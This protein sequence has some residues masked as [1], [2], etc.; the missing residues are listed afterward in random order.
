METLNELIC[1]VKKADNNSKKNQ[2]YNNKVYIFNNNFSQEEQKRRLIKHH[3]S[4]PQL[5]TVA[6]PY[7]VNK[8]DNRTITNNS[9]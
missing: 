2:Q 8:H 4:E 3:L 6:I 7:L 9:S 1:W 5:H